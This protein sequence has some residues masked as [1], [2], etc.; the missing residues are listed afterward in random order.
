MYELLWQSNSENYEAVAFVVKSSVDVD[1]AQL[2]SQL[3]SLCREHLP[4]YMVPAEYRIAEELPLTASGKVDFRKL[5][6]EAQK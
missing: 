3:P 6:L 2:I 4:T 5:E 1:D